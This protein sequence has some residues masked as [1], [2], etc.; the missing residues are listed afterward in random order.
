MCTM[1]LS[2]D[3]YEKIFKIFLEEDYD[4]GKRKQALYNTFFKQDQSRNKQTMLYD[5]SKNIVG[6]RNMRFNI[7]RDP[8]YNL[9]YSLEKNSNKFIEYLGIVREISVYDPIMIEELLTTRYTH[10]ESQYSELYMK[11]CK[12]MG[13]Y[14]KGTNDIVKKILQEKN[15]PIAV[16]DHCIIPFLF[17]D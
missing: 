2:E 17:S 1:E 11:I 13:I 16:I 7:M 8:P 10:I 6:Q 3:D 12:Y 4:E 14:I 5:K 15:I 9:H